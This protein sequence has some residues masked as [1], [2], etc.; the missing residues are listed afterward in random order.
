MKIT[1]P[2]RKLRRH[3]LAA[4]ILGLTLA[5]GTAIW[6]NTRPATDADASTS[7]PGAP[8]S[9]GRGGGN[10]TQPVSVT[11]VKQTTMPQWLQAIGTVIARN[12]VTVRSR[13][14]GELMRIAFNEGQMVKAGELLAEIDPRPFQVQLAQVSG[15]LARDQ[16]LLQNAELDLKRY[17]ELWAKDS[18]ARQQLDTQEAL[19]RQYQGTVEV[20]KGAVDNARLQLGYARVVAPISG[21]VGL[22]NVDPGN[23]VR[24]GD[25]NGIASIA[26][27]QPI[28]VV[29]AVP[30]NHISAINRRLTAGEKL[31][32]EAWDREQKNR[33]AT[34]QLL[35]SDNQIDATTGT[36][37]LKA[38]FAN[39]DSALF[40]NQFVNVRLL[41]GTLENAIV[42][43]VAAIQRGARG[44][45]V[46]AVDAESTVRI[47]GVLPGASDGKLTAVSSELKPGERVV[48][49]GTDRLRPGAKVEIITA[50]ARAAAMAPPGGRGDRGGAKGDA[51]APPQ[52]APPTPAPANPEAEKSPAA[53]AA[54]S[55]PPGGT[56]GKPT[57]PKP[58]ATSP[59]APAASASPTP[60]SNPW[61]EGEKPRWWD[62]VSPEVQQML[63][64]M[65][66]EDRRDWLI[67]RREERERAAAA[68]AQ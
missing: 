11:E 53:P 47:V 14:D 60:G 28:T 21:R 3:L 67:K 8:G 16:A 44:S 26:Q 63:M 65:S 32:V 62:R 13:V 35:T 43:P 64:K 27:L 17:R 1:P 58:D 55:S 52:A 7:K 66:P 33:L 50:E 24:A 48:T 49:D 9:M 23:L 59:A 18:I 29:F 57:P 4:I 45:F 36:I 46:Y 25:A 51:A 40:P 30:E 56:G 20:G 10:R 6:W 54:K 41:L 2:S 5:A 15:Q 37:K 39:Q 34:G 68:G 42:V 19:V 22:R 38:E 61:G 31:Q 12:Q